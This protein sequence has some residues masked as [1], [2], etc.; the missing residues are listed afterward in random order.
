MAVMVMTTNRSDSLQIDRIHYKSIRITT[1]LSI[2][3]RPRVWPSNMHSRTKRCL[4]VDKF[5]TEFK[6]MSVRRQIP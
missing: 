1:N 2:T 4:S 5:H 3:I 6:V